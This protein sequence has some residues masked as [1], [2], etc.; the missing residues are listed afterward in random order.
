V[1][2]HTSNHCAKAKACELISSG[3]KLDLKFHRNVNNVARDL[4]GPTY[5]ARVEKLRKINTKKY[6]SAEI[7]RENHTHHFLQFGWDYP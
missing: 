4:W 3:S 5:E 1:T 6:A 7:K 2:D